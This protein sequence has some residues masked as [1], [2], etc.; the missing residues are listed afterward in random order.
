MS[1]FTAHY[2]L[3]AANLRKTGVGAAPLS[4]MQMFH[5]RSARVGIKLRRQSPHTVTSEV[6]RRS[7]RLAA[8]QHKQ[9]RHVPTIERATKDVSPV[10][11]HNAALVK[12]E[13]AGFTRKIKTKTFPLC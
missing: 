1:D 11:T 2:S 10:V 13:H 12:T 9:S 6:G 8:T 4:E 7:Q 5:I 3:S